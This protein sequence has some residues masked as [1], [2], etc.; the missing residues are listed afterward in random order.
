MAYKLKD[1]DRCKTT[2]AEK[3]SSTVIAAGSMVALSSGLIIAGAAASAELAWCP[4]GAANGTTK[5][6]VTVGN[7]FTLIGSASTAFAV[8]NRGA[9]VDM[10]D[11]TQKIN[12]GASS[13]DVFKV[14]IR[15]E[16][17]TAGSVDNIEVRI[18]KPLF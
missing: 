15:A 14:G 17:G 16:S 10:N 5:V 13:T 4:K 3:G 18:N 8:A 2:I 12:L 11:T 9:E 1:G 7:D 6:E